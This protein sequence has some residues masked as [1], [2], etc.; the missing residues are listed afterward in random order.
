[1]T[2]YEKEM[3]KLDEIMSKKKQFANDVYLYKFYHEAEKGQIDKIG[4]MTI[5]E[6]ERC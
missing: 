1:M 5:E 6:A 4:N 3:Q 2:K